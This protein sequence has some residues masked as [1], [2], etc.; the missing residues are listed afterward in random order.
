VKLVGLLPAL[1]EIGIAVAITAFTEIKGAIARSSD[2]GRK[3][4]P[5]EW[6]RI[7]SR[8]AAALMHGITEA[9]SPWLDDDAVALFSPDTGPTSHPAA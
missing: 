2:G 4:T 3:I 1:I 6:Q 5:N 9:A 8:C 7:A